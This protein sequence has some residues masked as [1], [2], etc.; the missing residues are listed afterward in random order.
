MKIN[1]Q[2]VRERLGVWKQKVKTVVFA[3]VFECVSVCVCGLC[4]WERRISRKQEKGLKDDLPPK[5]SE[6]GFVHIVELGMSSKLAKWKENFWAKKL[7]EKKTTTEKLFIFSLF[8][9]HKKNFSI[10]KY[11]FFF[12]FLFWRFVFCS[13]FWWWKKH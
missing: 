9:K 6:R 3:C 11:L 2:I 8:F 7:R 12:S 5:G 13:L 1:N 4:M 10:K